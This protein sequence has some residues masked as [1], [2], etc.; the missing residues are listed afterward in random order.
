M[1]TLNIQ[2][3]IINLEKVHF[4]RRETPH[5]LLISFGSDFL[6]IRGTSEIV[7]DLFYKIDNALNEEF[8]SSNRQ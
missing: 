2:D 7:D 1:K 3:K 8:S 4:V 6:R 5:E